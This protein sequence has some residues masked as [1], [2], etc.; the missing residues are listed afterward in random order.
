MKFP[1]IG[2]R[3]AKRFAYFLS[4]ADNEFVDELSKLIKEIKNNAVQCVSCRRYFENRGNGTSDKCPICSSLNRNLALLMVVEKNLD[5]DNIE[6][7][8]IYNGKYFILG[9]ALSLKNEKQNS[10]VIKELFNKAQKEKPAEVIL[11]TSATLEGEN[12]ARYIEKIL[13]PLPIKVT[14]L[15]RGLSTGTELEYIDSETMNNALKNRK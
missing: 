1:G 4:S 7:T 8:G 11:A 3:Q 12:T 5:L 13:E 9:S 15:G 6:K 14:R 2:P 10:L